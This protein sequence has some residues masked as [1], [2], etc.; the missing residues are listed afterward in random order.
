MKRTVFRQILGLFAV[1]LPFA[2][3][4]ACGGNMETPAGGGGE[5]F[6]MGSLTTRI[7]PVSGP[8]NAGGSGAT[9]TGL[10]GNLSSARLTMLG[11]GKIAFYS[12]R[13][14]NPEIYVMNPDGT[15]QTRLTSSIAGDFVPAW[16]PDGSKIAFCSGSMGQRDIYV[17]NADG[18][19]P[20]R[21]TSE[22][23]DDVNPSW[24]PDGSK[25][26][27]ASNRDGNYEVYVMNA[28][29]TGQTR[30]TVIPGQDDHPR[31]SPDGSRI[32]FAS[33]RDG[34]WEI[35]VM[36]ADGSGQTRLTSHTATDY[37]PAWSPD[38]S[39]IAFMSARDGDEEIYVMNADSTGLTQLTSNSVTDSAPF[40]SP[41]GRR[42]AFHAV[43]NWDIYVM[44]AD[45][46]GRTQLTTHPA[47]DYSPAWSKGMTLNLVGAGG[48]LANSAGGFL[49]ARSGETPRSFL[50]FDA[51]SR[52]S[53]RLSAF[54]EQ[55]NLSNAVFHLTA[56]SITSMKIIDLQSPRMAVFTLVGVGGIPPGTK[57]MLISYSTSSGRLDAVIPYTRSRSG[58]AP[59]VHEEK[60]IQVLRGEFPA[61]LD[62]QGNNLA[63]NG[64]SE[65]RIDTR[66]GKIEVR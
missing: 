50:V 56:D 4:G 41:D 57:A 55:S 23:G 58:D 63:P 61:V 49:Y 20:T 38:G 10:T 16:S 62:A 1:T 28:D 60:D 64:A 24:S 59:A 11:Q 12:V 15:E 26:V 9:I 42:I 7:A 36:N 2:M 46:T 65:V 18:T 48:R 29:G 22:A 21:L 52:S 47:D 66:T 39:K 6:T 27:F 13:D 19:E 53:L 5:E 37:L 30:L 45:G 17:M 3:L 31:W 40:W 51:S 8:V 44:N 32:A 34:N 54:T 33:T 14:G 35:Y 43:G 25:L